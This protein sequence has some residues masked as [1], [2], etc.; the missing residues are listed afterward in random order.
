[1]NKFLLVTAAAVL[2]V[3]P[4][5]GSEGGGREE[6]LSAA[7]ELLLERLY[8]SEERERVNSALRLGRYSHPEVIERLIY[9]AREDPS[10]SVRRVALRSLGSIGDERALPAILEFTEDD[11]T[12][13]MI[14]A[15]SAAVRFEDPRVKEM[16][17]KKAEASNPMVRQRA[18]RFLGEF[19]ERGLEGF[20][21]EK[22]G[23][24][25]EGVRMA[26]V[27]SLAGRD[28]SRVGEALARVL[29]QDRSAAVRAAAAEVLG[30]VP[31]MKDPL[32]DAL[33]DS[34]I[35]VRVRAAE[36]LA[37]LGSRAG[38]GVAV[39]GIKAQDYRARV[40][41]CRVIGMAGGENE[42]IFLE[43]AAGDHDRRVQRAAESA[44]REMDRRLRQNKSN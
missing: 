28:S 37:V 4:V 9:L 43:R 14:E 20:I 11:N 25:S 3:F 27:E 1:M 44:L 6:T 31:G 38:L 23:D 42:R 19:N 10:D 33:T 22:L 39:E 36:S 7:A 26:A 15:V 21:L 16:L 29:E 12:A 30:G 8:S 13:V 32:K 2:S 24:V 34:D 5:Y 17:L 35:T 40:I 41:S 18:V